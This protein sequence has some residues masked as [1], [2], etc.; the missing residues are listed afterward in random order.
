MRP[1][2]SL[3]NAQLSTLRLTIKYIATRTA[4]IEEFFCATKRL[5]ALMLI[6]TVRT[7]WKNNDFQ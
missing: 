1:Q 6:W 7:Q 3:F 5:K 4:N 2:S